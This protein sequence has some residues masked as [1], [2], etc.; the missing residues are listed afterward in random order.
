MSER[1]DPD[2]ATID[3]AGL[4][5]G[6]GDPVHDGQACFRTVLDA[7]A[8]P[9][10][11]LALPFRLAAPPPR[12]LE[13]GRGGDRARALRFRDAALARCGIARRRQLSA[14]PLRRRAARGA[15]NG[16]FRLRR[17]PGRAAAPRRVRARHGRV[18]RPLD[19]AGPGR[20]GA[21]WGTRRHALRG[22]GSTAR[23][24]L[25]HRGSATASGRSGRRC[26]RSCRAASISC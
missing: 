11:I 22:R 12:A 23:R 13:P 25:R 18:S 4:A 2:I 10:R 19:D 8:H 17:Q 24:V 7:M 1:R 26:A 16:A 9:G 5:P 20:H 3:A 21:R 15:R 6:L 14:L